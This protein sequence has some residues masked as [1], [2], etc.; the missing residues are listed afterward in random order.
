M[1]TRI[2]QTP[3]AR[4]PSGSLRIGVDTGGTFTDFVCLSSDGLSLHKIRSTPDDPSR[5]VLQGLLTLAGVGEVREIVHGS[6]IATNA[7]LERKGARVALLATEGF[8]DALQ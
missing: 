4:Q 6:T 7:V 8:Q 2:P 3:N 1:A 5:A